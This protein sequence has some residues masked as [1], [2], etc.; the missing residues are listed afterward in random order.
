MDIDILLYEYLE[1]YF[2]K[3]GEL[4]GDDINKPAT[5]PIKLG[6]MEI[7]T[8]NITNNLKNK[9]FYIGPLR[10]EPHLQYDKYYTDKFSVGVKGENCAGVLF[11]YKDTPWEFYGNEDIE[12]KMRPNDYPLSVHVD[13]WLSYLGVAEGVSAHFEG[14]YGYELKIKPIENRKESDL[15]NVG[16]GVS[17][18]LPIILTC[19]LA[20]EVSTII[21]EQPELHLH[22]AMQTKLTDFFIAVMQCNKQVIIETHSEH[23]IN[24]L[25]YKVVTTEAPDDDKL[26]NNIQIYFTEMNKNGSLF[27]SITM[28]KYAYMSEWPDGFF[29]EA[30]VN[31]INTL[32]AINRKLEKDP[33][34]D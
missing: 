2:R 29:D 19:I 8:R 24:A 10:E 33:P 34:R 7:I 23:I 28:N 11:S 26:A 17:Q 1:N 22:P 14:R 3:K 9:I 16:V 15:T 30:Q 25:R 27:K 20:P 32:Y 4:E 12:G 6:S 21:I 31:N 18:V 5:L 13:Q